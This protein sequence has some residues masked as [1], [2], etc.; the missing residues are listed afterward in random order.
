MSNHKARLSKLE[1][2]NAARSMS[3]GELVERVNHILEHPETA[4]RQVYSRITE[5][6]EIAKARRAAH[7]H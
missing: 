2:Q 6:I 3:D 7:E 4:P 1:K 5:L